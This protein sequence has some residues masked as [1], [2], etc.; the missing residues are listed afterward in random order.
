MLFIVVSNLWSNEYCFFSSIWNLQLIVKTYYNQTKN[1]IIRALIVLYQTFLSNE[2]YY[3]LR[4]GI[5]N[6]K[7]IETKY[8]QINV[9]QRVD[10]R[11]LWLY[12]SSGYICVDG[13]GP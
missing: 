9:G 6:G 3:V 8:I 13:M 5:Y 1:I 12:E 7:K 11:V 2:Y 4:F 10:A